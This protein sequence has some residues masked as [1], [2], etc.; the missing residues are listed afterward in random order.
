MAKQFAGGF[1]RSRQE[2]GQR[3][4]IPNVQP[5]RHDAMADGPGKEDARCERRAGLHGQNA[6]QPNDQKGSQDAGKEDD[7]VESA[8]D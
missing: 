1:H 5:V 6:D 4:A 7:L 2:A 8:I 3:E